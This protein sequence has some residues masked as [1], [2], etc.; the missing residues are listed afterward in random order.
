MIRKIISIDEEKCNGCGLCASVCAENAIKIVNGKAKLISDALCDGLGACL[1]HCP[2]GAIKIIER[3]ADEFDEDLVKK[4]RSLSK[5]HPFSTVCPT[6]QLKSLDI[7][8]TISHWPIK[9][10]LISSSAPFFSN[11]D[12]LICADCVPP[13]YKNF[14]T[15]LSAQKVLLLGCPKFDSKELYTD[16]FAQIFSE[17]S[18]NS[19]LVA[20]MEVPCCQTLPHLVLAGA[21]KANK[22]ISLTK[23]T[24]SIKGEII[25]TELMEY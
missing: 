2:T 20:V 14:H 16:K 23:I 25:K 17:H 7:T 8:S 24:V 11:S 19:I 3:D 9:I 22:K 6:I 21:R 13:T 18:I 10:K 15:E 1:P 12:L 5:D 4:M